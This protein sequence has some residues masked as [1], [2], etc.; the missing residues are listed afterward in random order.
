VT[1]F[2]EI[3]FWIAAVW[4]A[5]VL[6]LYPG[7]TVVVGSMLQRVRKPIRGDETPRISFLIS[8]YNEEKVI[9]H[10]LRLTLELDYPPDR[11][12]VI[13][14]SDAC[15]DRTDEIVKELGDPRVRLHRVEGRVGKTAALNSAAL[16]ATGELLVFSDATGQYSH[17]ALRALAAR[18][19]DPSVGCVSGR[20]VYR[21]GHDVTS[22]GFRGY[23][24]VAVAVRQAENSFGDQTSVSGSIHAVRRE[25]FRPSAPAFS[26]DVLDAVHTVVHG[27]RVVYEAEAVS[28]EDSRS[29]SSQEFK[30]RVRISVQNNAMAPY[31]ARELVRSRRFFYLFQ[32]VSHKLMRWWLWLPLSSALVSSLALATESAAFRAVAAAQLAFYAV[33]VAGLAREWSSRRFGAIAAVAS[34]FVMGNVAMCVGTIQGLL[35]AERAAWEPQR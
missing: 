33:A 21:Y 7:L 17:N 30:A 29:S 24:K 14:V 20:V 19:A 16:T 12:E 3:A 22:Q 9:A 31:I 18:F 2:T 28:L 32:M 10:K 11:I 26:P 25:L 8:A 5:Y 35:G 27:R 23:Q 6:V 15:T 13:V 1:T 4:I 34:F